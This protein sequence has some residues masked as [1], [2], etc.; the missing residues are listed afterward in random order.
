MI[1]TAG[2]ERT[3]RMSG[4]F[5]VRGFCRPVNSMSKFLAALFTPLSDRYGLSLDAIIT[6]FEG[7]EI[8]FSVTMSASRKATLLPQEILQSIAGEDGTTLRQPVD[9]AKEAE[10]LWH[11]VGV[12]PIGIIKARIITP[13]TDDSVIQVETNGK[14]KITGEITLQA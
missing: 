10:W 12:L 1:Y 3:G 4:Q 2:T 5:R 11:A 13:A 6:T 7:K 8:K 9:D 14:I